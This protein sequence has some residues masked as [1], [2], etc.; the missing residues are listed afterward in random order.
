MSGKT[1]ELAPTPDHIPVSLVRDFDF[2]APPGAEDD[3]QQAWKRVQDESPDVFWTPRNGGHWIA[4]RA[5][6]IHEVQTNFERYSQRVLTL[7]VDPNG[8]RLIPVNIDPPE[9]G[10][11]RK[12]IMPAFLPR[13]ID[14]LDADIRQVAMEVIDDLAPRGECEFVEDFA[15]KLPIAIFMKIVDLPYADREILL[16]WT[17]QARENPDVEVLRDVL[18]K[19][20]GYLSKWVEERRARPGDDLISAVVH[21]KIGD[22]P[23]NEDEIF[24]LLVVILFG[25][26]DTVTAM[27]SF[28]CRFLATHPE[29]RRELIDH[30][31]RRRNAVEELIRRHGVVATARYITE[32]FVRGGVQFKAGDLIQ[33]PNALYGLDERANPDPL[34]VDFSREDIRLGAFGHGPHSCPG[35]VLTRREITAFIDCWLAR[36]PDFSLKPGSKPKL[37]AGGVSGVTRL[38]LVWPTA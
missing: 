34:T 12:I 11:Y 33:I 18:T 9:H 5:E 28:I 23:I 25:G 31:E 7:P 29:H 6:D 3:V 2:F 8:Y 17:D 14:R 36:I 13:A 4:T 35:A 30:P 19:M 16:P 10:L 20:M 38:E 37:N 32:D 21:A 1:S 26:L 15:R 24:N 22:R 27:L